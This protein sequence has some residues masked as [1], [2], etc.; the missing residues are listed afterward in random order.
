VR[1]ETRDYELTMNH[2]ARRLEAAHD[3]IA[4]R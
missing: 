1:R 2:W 4:T 3:E